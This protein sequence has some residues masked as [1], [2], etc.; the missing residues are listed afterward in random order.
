[1]FVFEITKKLN[2][3]DI[4]EDNTHFFTQDDLKDTFS[5]VLNLCNDALILEPYNI[6]L[7]FIK[8][9]ILIYQKDHNNAS[10]LLE[11]IKQID[12]NNSIIIEKYQIYKQKIQKKKKNV[13]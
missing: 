11:E 10:Q 7:L 13:L 8:L 1:M 5:N 4:F 3:P 2:K 6:K 12:I 9:D